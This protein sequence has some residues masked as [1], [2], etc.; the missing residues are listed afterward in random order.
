MRSDCPPRNVNLC[1]LGRVHFCRCAVDGTLLPSESLQFPDRG[2]IFEGLKA[3]L[4][5]ATDNAMCVVD[6]SLNLHAIRRDSV[7]NCWQEDRLLTAGAHDFQANKK[8]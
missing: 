6:H 2:R 4:P 1:L 5:L 8:Q 3:D 7:L